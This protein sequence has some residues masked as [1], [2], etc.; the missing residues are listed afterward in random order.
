MKLRKIAARVTPV[1]FSEN[2]D[3]SR[4]PRHG[5]EPLSGERVVTSV[6]QPYELL[7]FIVKPPLGFRPSIFRGMAGLLLPRSGE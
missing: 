4:R 2:I 5:A 3:V 1:T 6:S 7:L